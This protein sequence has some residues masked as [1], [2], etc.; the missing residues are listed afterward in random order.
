MF[1]SDLGSV[2]E[3][4]EPEYYN[5]NQ[6][7]LIKEIS[8]FIT[9][10]L[11]AHYTI[12][13]LAERFGISMTTLKKGF[14]GVYGTSVY[15]WL[16]NYRMQTAQKILLETELSVSEIAHQIVVLA[17]GIVAEKDSH[18]TLMKKHGLYRKLVDLQTESANW[19]LS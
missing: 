4:Q 2:E 12:R 15:S 1:L 3:M 18:E 14:H 13:Q 11:T 5:Q 16:R 10:D 8:A 9:K 19:K 17:D 6:V 7:K